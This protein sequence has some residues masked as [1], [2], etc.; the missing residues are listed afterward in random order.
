MEIKPNKY[1][2]KIEKLT[3]LRITVVLLS[4]ILFEFSFGFFFLIFSEDDKLNKNECVLLLYWTTFLYILYLVEFA[5]AFLCFLIGIFSLFCFKN[6]LTRIYVSFNNFFKSIIFLASL[7]C[8]VIISY[9]YNQDENCGK[10]RSLTFIWMVFHFLL[11]S[12][13]LLACC[14]VLIITFMIYFKNKKRELS[15]RESLINLNV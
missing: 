4:E 14:I 11:L 13:A 5:I 2:T 12:V 9:A 1:E 15:E 6:L 3:L 8:L 7:F 10:L